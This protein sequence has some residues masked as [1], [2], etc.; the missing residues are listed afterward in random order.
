MF[1]TDQQFPIVLVIGLVVAQTDLGSLSPGLWGHYQLV[2]K[3]HKHGL[4]FNMSQKAKQ[5]INTCKFSVLSLNLTGTSTR[6]RNRSTM[7]NKSTS[8]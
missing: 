1:A 8:S 7:M 4:L 5:Y 3:Y 2:Y 6:A